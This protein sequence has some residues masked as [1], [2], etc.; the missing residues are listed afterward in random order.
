MPVVYISIDNDFCLSYLISVGNLFL[1]YTF[2]T[3]SVNLSDMFS[4]VRIV[5]KLVILV[6]RTIFHSHTVCSY[7]LVYYRNL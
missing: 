2:C 7:V 5:V 1:K 3:D 4:K 6:L